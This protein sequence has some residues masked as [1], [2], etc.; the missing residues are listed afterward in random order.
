[1]VLNEKKKEVATKREREREDRKIV[2]IFNFFK[3]CPYLI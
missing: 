3:G 2:F 1:M